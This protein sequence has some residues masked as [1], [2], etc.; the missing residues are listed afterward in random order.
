MNCIK[1]QIEVV[2][3]V[4]R[5]SKIYCEKC[6]DLPDEEP[7][8]NKKCCKCKRANLIEDGYNIC[9]QCIEKLSDKLMCPKCNKVTMCEYMSDWRP[10]HHCW[11]CSYNMTYM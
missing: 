5:E 11:N 1:C 6:K 2:N 8:Q 9:E 7:Q 3:G 10:N 4:I